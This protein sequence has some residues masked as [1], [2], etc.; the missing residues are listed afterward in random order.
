M[1]KTEMRKE[2]K[3]HEGSKEVDEIHVPSLTSWVKWYEVPVSLI[4]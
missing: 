3:R 2:R 1:E 4:K